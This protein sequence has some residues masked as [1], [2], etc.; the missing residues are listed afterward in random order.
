MI[1]E[2][3]HEGS[4]EDREE[5]IPAFKKD[6][7]IDDGEEDNSGKEGFKIILGYSEGGK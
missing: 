2:E 1:M 7:V 5:V 6:I 3:D 4:I